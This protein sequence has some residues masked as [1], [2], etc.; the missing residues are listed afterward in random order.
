MGEIYNTRYIFVGIGGPTL[1]C[2][3]QKWH[4]PHPGSPAPKQILPE[5]QPAGPSG[6]NHSPEYFLTVNDSSKK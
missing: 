1:A 5:A 2:D 3:V 6:S 4:Q